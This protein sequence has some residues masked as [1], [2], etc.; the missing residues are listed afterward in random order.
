MKKNFILLFVILLPSI[1]WARLIQTWTYQ[2]MFDKADLVVIA[3]PITSKVISEKIILPDIFPDVHVVGVETTL[4]NLVMLKG[5]KKIKNIILHHY[6]LE[7]SSE[8][9]FSGPFL[10]SFDLTKRTR[11]ILFLKKEADGRYAPV[12]GQTDPESTSVI[13]LNDSLVND[14]PR[15]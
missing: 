11:F 3:T 5:D 14:T 2:E 13:R 7:N 1:L 12:T 10:I 4:S 9:M 8:L 15:P 6:Q